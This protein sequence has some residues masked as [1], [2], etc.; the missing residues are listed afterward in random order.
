MKSATP[1][2]DTLVD[3]ATPD[4]TTFNPLLTTEQAAKF[5]QISPSCLE[6]YRSTGE[7]RI[8]V[9]HVGSRLRRYKLSDLQRF[10][11]QHTIS[12]K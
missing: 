12:R 2:L 11:E 9:V 7:V 6:R 4:I 10:A 8:P 5:L 1:T 3:T